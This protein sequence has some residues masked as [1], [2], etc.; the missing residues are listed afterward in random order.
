MCSPGIYVEG[1]QPPNVRCITYRSFAT[2][3][4]QLKIW[5]FWVIG[6]DKFALGSSPYCPD[7]PRPRVIGIERNVCRCTFNRYS[8]NAVCKTR[9]WRAVVVLIDSSKPLKVSL[10]K[11][12]ILSWHCRHKWA[13]C[14]THICH[15]RHSH[16]LFCKDLCRICL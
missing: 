9:R 8:V 4:S 2:R 5:H 12:H 7:A 15:Q 10:E 6:I 11:S 1:C 13:I 3:V 14:N 16:G